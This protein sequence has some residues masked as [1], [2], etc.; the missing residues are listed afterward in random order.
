MP[1]R[2]PEAV[3][4]LTPSKFIRRGRNIIDL[5]LF[6]FAKFDRWRDLRHFNSVTNQS[7][8]DGS[9]HEDIGKMMVFAAHNV[10]TDDLGLKLLKAI[11]SYVE[12]DI[13]TS[14][15]LHT[16]DTIAAGRK[17]LQRFGDM[18]KVRQLLRIMLGLNPQPGIHCC[19]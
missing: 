10:L 15:K 9:K 3:L 8:N 7:F 11:R 4:K 5:D 14:F 1:A 6:R 17:A 18:M 2:L 13:Y 19:L 12:L 16:S